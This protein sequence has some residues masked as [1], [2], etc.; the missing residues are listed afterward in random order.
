MSLNYSVSICAY[1]PPKIFY[2][3]INRMEE[4]QIDTFVVYSGNDITLPSKLN[5]VIVIKEFNYGIGHN[6]NTGIQLALSNGFDLFTLLT[7]DAFILPDFSKNYIVDYFTK[8][9][10]E[11]DVLHINFVSG[12]LTTKKIDV[13]T[14][15]TVSSYI[16]RRIKFREDF[17]MD[18]QDIY[19]CYEVS[20]IGGTI[21]SIDR[22]ML[23]VLPVGR[24]M[25]GKMH[26]LPSFRV[27]LLTRNT[28]RIFI[29][30]KKIHFLLN[31]IKFSSGY[32]LKGIID[33]EKRML[34][35]YFS[36]IIDA[37]RGNLEISANLQKLSGNKFCQLGPDLK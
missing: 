14:G 35:A 24:M 31:F 23:D 26:Y 9:C 6:F 1:N 11:N 27:Y 30:S 28:L 36:G 7:D 3:T 19:F 13:D 17:V 18:Q 37:M 8:N 25:S 5:Y 34:F 15:M 20:N 12:T 2:D 21:R 4:M 29:E 10:N 16:A 22:K 33:H 32:L